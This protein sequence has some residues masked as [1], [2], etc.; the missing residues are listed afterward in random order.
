MVVVFIKYNKQILP[1]K[2]ID[3]S[4]VI[5]AH[6]L[7]VDAVKFL[8]IVICNFFIFFCGNSNMAAVNCPDD[9]RK[10]PTYK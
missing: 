10:F 6:C 9:V 2:Y 5:Q 8:K 4:Q 1:N 7:K 3:E